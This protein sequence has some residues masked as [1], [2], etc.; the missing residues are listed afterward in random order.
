MPPPLFPRMSFTV[1]TWVLMVKIMDR[2][3]VV[4]VKGKDDRYRRNYPGFVT[5]MSTMVTMMDYASLENEAHQ[6]YEQHGNPREIFILGKIYGV[7]RIFTGIHDFYSQKMAAR[8]TGCVIQYY[9]LYG[10]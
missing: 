4:I 6:K 5:A 7:G 1:V 3:P 8:F 10:N 9:Y 2:A